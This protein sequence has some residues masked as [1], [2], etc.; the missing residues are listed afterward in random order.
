MRSVISRIDRPIALANCKG[1]KPID[2]DISHLN[3]KYIKNDIYY[4]Q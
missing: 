3:L 1:F 2:L 4:I